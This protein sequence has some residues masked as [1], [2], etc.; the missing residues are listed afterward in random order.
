VPRPAREFDPSKRPA[1]PGATVLTVA[2]Q[3]YTN[4]AAKFWSGLLAD[5][6]W[7][8][9]ECTLIEFA[10]W[11]ARPLTPDYLHPDRLISDGVR[12]LG[13]GSLREAIADAV[14]EM[15]LMGPPASVQIRMLARNR[16]ILPWEPLPAFVDAELFPFLFVWLLEWGNVPAAIWNSERVAGSFAASD[17]HFRCAYEIAFNM[18]TRHVSEG[19]HR[20]T[21]SLR[22]THRPDPA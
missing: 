16:V 14:A 2:G 12:R 1:R 20:L 13:E 21:L 7:Q 4:T 10:S 6:F 9:P 5:V 3:R 11:L 17:K 18:K 15:D 19:L 22:V 8:N